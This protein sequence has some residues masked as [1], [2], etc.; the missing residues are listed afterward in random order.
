MHEFGHALESHL[1]LQVSEDAIDG[2]CE[3]WEAAYA[4]ASND[5]F[6]NGA[7]RKET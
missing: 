7:G 4:R 1:G 3:A 5:D 2:A 6:S